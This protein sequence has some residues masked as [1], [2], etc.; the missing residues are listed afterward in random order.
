[1]NEIGGSLKM[2]FWKSKQSKKN[3]KRRPKTI[4]QLLN[5]TINKEVAKDP[6]LRRELAH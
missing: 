4:K 6:D 2:L 1:M 5:E 3:Q